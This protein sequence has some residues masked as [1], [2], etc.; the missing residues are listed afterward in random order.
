LWYS[1]TLNYTTVTAERSATSAANI[2]IHPQLSGVP[3]PAIS[4]TQME[5]KGLLHWWSQS[6]T[7]GEP[8]A[9]RIRSD[10]E[11]RIE[12]PT[13]THQFGDSAAVPDANRLLVVNDA[14]GKVVLNSP[15]TAVLLAN[16][17]TYGTTILQQGTL[18]ISGAAEQAGLGSSFQLFNNSTIALTGS[19]GNLG[20]RNGK[21][22]GSGTVQGS[23]GL[24][25][26]PGGDA[27]TPI[28][29][30]GSEGD[31]IGTITVT[32]NFQMFSGEMHIE[33]RGP[34]DHDKIVVGGYAAM[35]QVTAPGQPA[36]AGGKVVGNLLEKHAFIPAMM[37]GQPTKLKFL[38][39]ANNPSNS[40]FV[41]KDKPVPATAWDYD[42]D[43]TNAW[44]TPLQDVQAVA[45]NIGG[46]LWLDNGAVA[47]V[48]EAGE[49]GMAGVEVR[50]LDAGGNQ[51]A[52]AV[53]DANGNF[54]FENLAAGIFLVEFDRPA[55]MR[56]AAAN[57]TTSDLDS[58]PDPNTG[59]VRVELYADRTD[60]DAGYYANSNPTADDDTARTHKNTSVT[61]NVLSNDTDTN[62]DSLCS[63]V[64]DEPEHGEVTL[65]P[66]G[67]FSYT[68]TRTTSGPI[69]SITSS[70]TATAG[71]PRAP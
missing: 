25:N 4:D 68:R 56:L 15:G 46:K 40:D 8:S 9:I 61:G 20:I 3:G 2:S 34:N 71:P 30:P 62:N 18:T 66:D 38:T 6:V 31:R 70:R 5:V 16:Y 23:L 44:F 48:R 26:A 37:N 54:A 32:A 17:H 33:I 53:A 22:V 28:I 55:G 43:A 19:G 59:R 24:G 1:G 64:E 67:S 63:T 12:T 36:T 60:I 58:D 21:I 41:A 13:G 47:G 69:R 42:I 10:G 45:G 49:G 7:V 39:R 57:A 29:S 11:F 27:T 14:G 35:H 50:L 52:D 51:L 65:N